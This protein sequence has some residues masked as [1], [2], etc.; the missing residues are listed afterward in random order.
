ME[1]KHRRYL[2]DAVRL[3]VLH[4]HAAGQRPDELRAAHGVPVVRRHGVQRRVPLA[5]GAGGASGRRDTAALLPLARPSA[6]CRGW[7]VSDGTGQRST[8]SCTVGR[9]AACRCMAISHGGVG[10]KARGGGEGG[11][12]AGGL[13]W[14]E[15]CD[16]DGQQEEINGSKREQ[17]CWAELD[18]AYEVRERLLSALQ[19][20]LTANSRLD[21]IEMLEPGAN[22]GG[23]TIK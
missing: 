14:R 6:Q 4:A 23:V 1:A 18:G 9:G 21:P 8:R 2:A 10:R 16:Y 13:P 11:G 7:Y 12:A 5:Q 17:S 15:G 22:A 19:T 20:Q 3:D